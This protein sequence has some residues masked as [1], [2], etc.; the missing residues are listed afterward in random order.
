MNLSSP[1]EYGT[2]DIMRQR[3]SKHAQFAYPSKFVKQQN[4]SEI[5]LHSKTCARVECAAWQQQ[6]GTTMGATDLSLAPLYSPYR[7]LFVS[8]TI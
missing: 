7:C 1:Y 8:H 5:C 3:Q 2:R 4:S 6:N